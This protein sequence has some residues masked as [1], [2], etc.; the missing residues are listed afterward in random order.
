[1]DSTNSYT[2]MLAS[3]DSM[4]RSGDQQQ[5]LSLYQRLAKSEPSR[6]EPWSRMAQIQ[7]ARGSYSAAVNSANEALRRNPDDRVARSTL[8]SAE[9]RV[10]RQLAQDN[11]S[12]NGARKGGK[13][14]A[15]AA[16]PGSSTAEADTA[17]VSLPPLPA[18]PPLETV[19]TPVMPVTSVSPV[20]PSESQAAGKKGGS[21]DP[22]DTLR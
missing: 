9:R 2:K 15:V 14:K 17:V 7:L 5:A 4:A 6:A 3:A 20:T 16:K 13:N 8:T 1:M 12:R 19:V 10:G 11:R 21:S 22:F 18:D